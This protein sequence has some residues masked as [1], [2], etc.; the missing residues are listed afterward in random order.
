MDLLIRPSLFSSETSLL[1]IQ[2]L[3][4]GPDLSF[5]LFLSRDHLVLANASFFKRFGLAGTSFPR[6]SLADFANKNAGELKGEIRGRFLDWFSNPSPEPS[7]IELPHPVSGKSRFLLRV[8]T[9]VDTGNNPIF[10]EKVQSSLTV[11]QKEGLFLLGRQ[12]RKPART[13]LRNVSD[14][15]LITQFFEDEL[16]KDPDGPHAQIF[17]AKASAW[18]PPEE[19]WWVHFSTDGKTLIAESLPEA[20]T[21]S[22]TPFRRIVFSKNSHEGYWADFPLLYNRGFFGKIRLFRPA[23]KKEDL[24]RLSSF[25]PKAQRLSRALFEIREHL[26][27]LHPE[28]REPESGFLDRREALLL[29]ES[30]I[31]EHRITGQG[32]GLIGI[33]VN[34]PNPHSLM[35]KVRNILRFYDEIAHV[36][37]REYVLILPSKDSQHSD[38]IIIERVR[39]LIL[40]KDHYQATLVT[41]GNLSY[42]ESGKG[43]MSLIRGVFA[44]EDSQPIQKKNDPIE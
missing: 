17:L 19:F 1:E 20:E 36:S 9:E 11:S 34:I 3:V 21:R 44:K 16:A 24:P 40:G 39:D 15:I 28:A 6:F 43:P 8:P 4:S 30:L 22:L 13:V 32:F 33:R 38:Q 14:E 10:L 27:F 12:L 23:S 42:P 35:L 31:E 7:M 26:E 25:Q 18:S 5:G 37:S 41:F 2:S 29:L